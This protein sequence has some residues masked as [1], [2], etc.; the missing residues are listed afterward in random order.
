MI[1]ESY[2]GHGEVQLYIVILMKAY[3]LV[4][5]NTISAVILGNNVKLIFVSVDTTV[6]MLY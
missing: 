4:Y 1:L 6:Q 5:F 2:Y 3:I